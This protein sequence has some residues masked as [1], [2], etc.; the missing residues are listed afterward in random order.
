MN[1]IE[2][3]VDSLE[4][5]ANNNILICSGT[6]VTNLLQSNNQEN[7]KESLSL[8]IKNTFRSLT[9]DDDDIAKLN[10]F[11]KNKKNLKITCSSVNFKFAL[12]K[13]IRNLKPKDIYFSEFLTPHRNNLYFQLRK[14]KREYPDRV[15][16]AYTRNGNIYCKIASDDN[17]RIRLIKDISCIIELERLVTLST[18]SA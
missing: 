5:Q 15:S 3:K 8:K 10:V 9:I 11:G 7:L 14:L 12:L 16:A 18:A 6:Y 17:Q 2:L 4:Q 1:N 13:E